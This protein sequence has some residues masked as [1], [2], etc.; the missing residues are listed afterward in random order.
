MI[1]FVEG[2]LPHRNPLPR[3]SHSMATTDPAAAGR[4]DTDYWTA[5]GNFERDIEQTFWFARTS[6]IQDRFI[7]V[8]PYPSVVKAISN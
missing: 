3:L 8:N 5:T 7:R 1:Q 2:A 6:L 4:M